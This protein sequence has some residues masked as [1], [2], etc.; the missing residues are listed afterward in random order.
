MG[1]QHPRGDPHLDVALPQR[2]PRQ[3]QGGGRLGE[4]A[5][6]AAEP[7]GHDGAQ[8]GV[9]DVAAAHQAEALRLVGAVHH[10]TVGGHHDEGDLGGGETGHGELLLPGASAPDLVPHR[11][12]GPGAHAEREGTTE[13]DRSRRH[14]RHHGEDDA[15][16]HGCAD[17][18]HPCLRTILTS[19][20]ACGRMGGP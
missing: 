1:I 18:G 17:Y 20:A 10:A 15:R 9:G 2:A 8:L 14:G 7:L 12:P 3:H 5:D 4:R 6:A 16:G 19:G 11:R 13:E